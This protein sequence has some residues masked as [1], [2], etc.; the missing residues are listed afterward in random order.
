M[1]TEVVFASLSALALGGGTLTARAGRR[2][3]VD[4]RRR[5]ARGARARPRRAPARRRAALPSCASITAEDAMATT[6]PEHLRL[7][8][9][10]DHRQAGA[11]R[12]PARQG[13]AD[14]QHREQVRLHAAV[15][16]P[17]KA[18]E[19]LPRQGPRRGRLSEQPVRRPGP[20]RERRDRVV[21]PA[22]LRRQLPDDGQGRRQRR[23]GRIRSGS[24]SPPKRRAC[25][26]PRRS[27][28][29]SPSS[30]SAATAR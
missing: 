22:Q 29:T 13:A 3:R 15:R 26:A 9:R 10:I 11:A 6:A 24:G 12:E 1:L 30:W 23:Q 4:R 7:R 16:R 27:S 8:G 19:G 14:R 18:V 20:G 2:R 17:R 28:G 5:A 21:L 25:S